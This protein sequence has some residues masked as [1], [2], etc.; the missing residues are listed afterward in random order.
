LVEPVTTISFD[1]T[2]RPIDPPPQELVLE[3]ASHGTRRTVRVSP[4][5]NVTVN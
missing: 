5:G 2:G 1:A 3:S 4:A